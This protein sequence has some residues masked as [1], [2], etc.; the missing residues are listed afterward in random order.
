[1]TEK[2][3]YIFIISTFLCILKVEGQSEALT[4]SP[5]SLYGLGAINQTGIGLTNGM[6][7]TGIGLKTDKEINNL[8]PANYALV[9]KTSFFYDVGVKA[10]YNTYSN[11]GDSEAKA[12]F[13]FSNLALAFSL[14]DGLGAG[15]TMVPYSD[16]GYSLLGLQTNIE[17]SNETFES[18]VT[19]L[20]GLND[21]RLNLGYEL[22][23]K[24]RLGTSLSFLFGSIEEDESFVISSSLFELSEQTN[25]FGVQLGFGMQYDLTENITIGSTLKL[26][27]T[28]DGTLK[29]SA[30]KIL[31]GS[32][33]TVED[34]EVDNVS[35]FKMPMELGFGLS[36]NLLEPLTLNMDY[37]KNFWDATEQSENI[38]EYTDQDIFALGAEYVSNSNGYKYGQR[39][40]YRAGFN[41]DNGYLSINN[42]KIDG[43]TLTA[44]IGFPV[45]GRGNS[46]VNLSY[47]YGSKGQVQNVLVQEN[48]H[49]LTLNLSLEDLWF[50]KR[51]I[52]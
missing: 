43:Y 44:G 26:P 11:V 29:R 37:K 42:S 19:G 4:S 51:K 15:I 9:P 12:N 52:N 25:Y 47:G 7:Y 48:Y 28:L 36:F 24:I 10:Q 45:G 21:L 5:Y 14:M 13:N 6:G 2:M 17:G 3:R 27:T 23:K 1:M 46:L 39:I 22:T 41:Y 49:L 32:E 38:G 40:R 20:G 30:I 34:N 50:I 8:N 16:V 18:N 31:E 35:G 33:I